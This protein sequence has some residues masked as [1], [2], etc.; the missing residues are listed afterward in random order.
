MHPVHTSC[1]QQKQEQ[2]FACSEC[3]N[4]RK[5][6]QLIGAEDLISTSSITMLLKCST[7]ALK[8]IIIK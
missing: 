3:I 1:S 8:I 2:D 4:I 7:T 5:L 6:E